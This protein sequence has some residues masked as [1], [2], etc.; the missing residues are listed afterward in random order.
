MFAVL[1]SRHASNARLVSLD[2]PS[3]PGSRYEDKSEMKFIH[4]F[5]L[6]NSEMLHEDGRKSITD[7]S[8]WKKKMSA[9]LLPS[10]APTTTDQIVSPSRPSLL[11]NKKHRRRKTKPITII[12]NR[13]SGINFT[14][15]FPAN[16]Q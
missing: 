15:L 5:R 6:P 4:S 7:L 9:G 2:V 13:T 16:R 12:S 3:N 14:E 10:G 1:L 11:V 8:N